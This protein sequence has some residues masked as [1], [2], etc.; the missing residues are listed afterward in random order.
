MPRSAAARSG[1]WVLAGALALPVN[2]A[3]CGR[4]GYEVLHTDGM[5]GD[6]DAVAS[7][8]AAITPPPDSGTDATPP[9][10]GPPPAMDGAP[11]ADSAA[12]PADSAAPPADSAAPPADSASVRDMGPPID[13]VPDMPAAA[14]CTFAAAADM[15]ADF[16]GGTLS[17]N[18][19]SGRGGP[20]FHLVDETAGTLSN[21]AMTNCGRRVMQVV[22]TSSR[23]PLVQ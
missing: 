5:G 11:P 21:V 2:A 9:I 3:G 7:P 20:S 17:T 14:S 12:P 23:A 16:E 13:A 1:R 19:V 22:A 8:D 4:V 15:I 18:R 6:A 10:D